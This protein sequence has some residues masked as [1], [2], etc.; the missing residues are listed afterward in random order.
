MEDH[1]FTYVEAIESLSSAGAR[2]LEDCSRVVLYS[3]TCPD[4]KKFH[5]RSDR[6]FDDESRCDGGSKSMKDYAES[7]C[8]ESTVLHRHKS[9]EEKFTL[10]LS[11]H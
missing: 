1:A 3:S 2:H 11:M 7:L 4:L 5:Q 6:G 9:G 8:R 10:R